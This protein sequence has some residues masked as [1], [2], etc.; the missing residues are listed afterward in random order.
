ME[1]L[2]KEMVVFHSRPHLYN[3]FLIVHD[4]VNYARERML[5]GPGRG[6]VGGTLVA[7]LLGITQL[8]PIRYDL[9]FERF[10]NAGRDKGMPDIDLDFPASKRDIMKQYVAKKY[11]GK[12]VAAVGTVA[13]MHP[14][15]A[16]QDIGRTLD[17]PF[18]DIKRINDLLD[19]MIKQGLQPD[20]WEEI[21][22]EIGNQLK[23]W[24]DRYPD[25]FRFAEEAHKIKRQYGIHA[26]GV[27]VA[28]EELDSLLPLSSRLPTGKKERSL[29][30]QFDYEMVDALGFMKIDFLGLKNLD[31]MESVD[32]LLKKQ[33]LD[34]IDWDEL[35]YEEVPDEMWDMLGEKL[36]TVGLFQI[37]DGPQA[38]NLLKQIKP[39]SIEDLA[40]HSAMNRPGVLLA[41][42]ENGRPMVDKFFAGRRGEPV[43][44]L[45]DVV[46]RVTEET[47]GVFI[48]QEQIIKYMTEIGYS[49]S[50]A[51][52]VRKIMGK[53][54]TEL[55]AEEFEHYLPLAKQHMSEE[56]ARQ[57]WSQIESFAR[58][59]F[60]KS[61]AV[62]YA[63]ITFVCAY[64][65]W[66]VARETMIS[67]LTHAED[68]KE[69]AR[70]INEA[71]RM[72]LNILPPRINEAEVDTFPHPEGL[73][74]GFRSIK[75]FSR[76]AANWIV[77]NRPFS[78]VEDLVEKA[79]ERKITMPNGRQTVAIDTAE[80][81]S[82]IR[83]GA[84]GDCTYQRKIKKDT[85]DTIESLTGTDLLDYEEE[86]FGVAIS[87]TS[88][89]ILEEY[90]DQIEEKCVAYNDIDDDGEY[91]VAGVISEVKENLRSK[92]GKI[93]NRI[94]IE[95]DGA[96]IEFSVWDNKI[97]ALQF[98]WRKRQAGIFRLKKKDQ[99]FNLIE[100]AALYPRGVNAGK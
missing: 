23:P 32:D 50:D 86:K 78:S 28:D 63:L 54:K 72:G 9:I 5:V 100:A 58:Y 60:N 13:E 61:H 6:S 89:T 64:K 22:N 76:N 73:M 24:I 99:Y 7:W 12:F 56:H 69:R 34:P 48:F 19:G 30:T 52:H 37:E 11:G 42:D 80:I 67:G 38:R 35:Q 55:I 2:K 8:D 4:I 45:N 39:R 51:D 27:V 16:I 26:S 43:T 33:G 82:L 79:Q 96:E 36:L 20:S 88:A 59:G 46:K 74:L 44:Y 29:V 93:Y 75:G 92:N 87:D 70:Y 85:Y 3:Y 14:K 84:F 49:L 66:K 41:K 18:V 94:K 95:H 47:F 65:K 40:I 1:R 83:L 71:R 10:Y 15:S 62:G 98:M 97:K 68:Q 17:I 81:D 31:H 25:L 57:I 53:K 21:Y 90:A 77:A 91:V